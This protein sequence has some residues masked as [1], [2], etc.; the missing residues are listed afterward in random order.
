MY[1]GVPRM[2][3]NFTLLALLGCGGSDQPRGLEISTVWAR[4]RN[5]EVGAEG[6]L[7]GANSA[8]YLE[9]WNRS[10]TPDRL[11]GGR[12]RAASRVEVHE[13]ILDGDVARMRQVQGVDLPAGAGVL[14]KPGGLHIMLLDLEESLVVGDTVSL[15]LSF[16]V[17]PDISLRVPIRDRGGE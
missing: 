11:L 7:S 12:T 4:P 14:L 9:I 6:P 16:L 8:V 1:Y 10:G 17:S 2:I 3:L 13:S 15:T 5:V